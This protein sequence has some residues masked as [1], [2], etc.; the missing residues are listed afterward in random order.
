MTDVPSD[1]DSE[2][3]AH[4]TIIEN[5]LELRRHTFKAFKEGFYPIVVGGD[6]SQILGTVLGMKKFRPAAKAIILDSKIDLNTGDDRKFSALEH[7]TGLGG[8][9]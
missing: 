7:L 6:N 3:D 1:G 9:E 8:K 2:F 5:S 4:Q